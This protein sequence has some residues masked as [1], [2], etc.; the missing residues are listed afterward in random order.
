M[1]DYIA[2]MNQGII[3][4]FG[5]PAEIYNKPSNTFVASFIGSPPM[6]FLTGKIEG[7]SAVIN[8]IGLKLPT[9]NTGSA[10]QD[11]LVGIRPQDIT[12]ADENTDGLLGSISLVELLGSEKLVEVQLKSAERIVVQIG[13]DHPAK[14]G[15][16]VRLRIEPE[17]L[18]VFDK[19][20]G[21][22]IR[23]YQ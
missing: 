2:V 13:A 21:F 12:L 1:S 7:E 10:E 5:T 18:H 4:Q 8:G 9:L 22:S 15:D 16:F 14:I 20:S 3:Q 19:T 17:K 6:N 23:S 11:V